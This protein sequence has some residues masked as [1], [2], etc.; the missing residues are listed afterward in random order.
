MQRREDLVPP[1]PSKK[2]RRE[3]RKARHGRKRRRSRSISPGPASRSTKRRDYPAAS[4]SPDPHD[5]RSQKRSR[6]HTSW[7]RSPPRH[8]RSSRSSP[9]HHEPSQSPPPR[10]LHDRSRS[11]SPERSRLNRSP[12]PNLRHLEYRP[13]SS[14]FVTPKAEPGMQLPP[15]PPSPPPTAMELSNRG[16]EAR[17]RLLEEQEARLTEEARLLEAEGI[18]LHEAEEARLQEAQKGP[19]GRVYRITGTNHVPLGTR[20]GESSAQQ[21]PPPSSQLSM[22]SS[23]A[24][25]MPQPSN[26]GKT[27]VGKT[28]GDYTTA[29][30]YEQ[31]GANRL[32]PFSFDSGSSFRTEAKASSAAAFP[33]VQPAGNTFSTA[34]PPIVPHLPGPSTRAPTDTLFPNLQM[35][36]GP[37]QLDAEYVAYV[38]AYQVHEY[39]YGFAVLFVNASPW[40]Y[41]ILGS[42]CVGKHKTIQLAEMIACRIAAELLPSDQTVLVRPLSGGFIERDYPSARKVFLKELDN[43]KASVASRTRPVLLQTAHPGSLGQKDKYQDELRQALERIVW[44]PDGNQQH[45]VFDDRCSLIIS[46]LPAGPAPIV[47]KS[48]ERVLKKSGRLPATPS[49]AFYGV[50]TPLDDFRAKVNEARKLFFARHPKA[51]DVKVYQPTEARKASDQLPMA[52]P[53]PRMQGS[54]SHASASHVDKKEY[55]EEAGMQRLIALMGSMNG[56]YG[57]G[58]QLLQPF[59]DALPQEDVRDISHQD[60]HVKY[61]AAVPSYGERPSYEAFPPSDPLRS[62]AFPESNQALPMPEQS[63]PFQ[64]YPAKPDLVDLLR[65]PPREEEDIEPQYFLPHSLGSQ[66]GDDDGMKGLYDDGGDERDEYRDDSPSNKTS[67]NQKGVMGWVKNILPF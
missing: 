13:N 31:L 24:P 67:S 21:V 66:Q 65:T 2:S 60:T 19:V 9:R 53:T 35:I 18:R 58:L 16:R 43:L 25:I 11:Y 51:R 42:T 12:V 1:R 29:R 36:T 30:A 41:R 49:P 63:S 5:H 52:A 55:S 44:I 28:F 8:R 27:P 59:G 62:A 40:G 39:E 15:R 6:R 32:Q 57:D 3:K 10:S 56:P 38:G 48:F 46:N 17:L 23:S 37:G 4:P 7:S 54:S 47:A 64:G 26:K 45:S 14:S 22:P 61:E 50:T 34:H 20:G 33:V